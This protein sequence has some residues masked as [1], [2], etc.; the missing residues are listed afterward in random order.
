MASFEHDK[1][2]ISHTFKGNRKRVELKSGP[3]RG[4]G[5]K[6][7]EWVTW[8]HDL[9]HDDFKRFKAIELKFSPRVLFLV[10]RNAL[11]TNPHP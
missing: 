6:I 3:R 11:L 8:L 2:S 4:R 1:L 5:R 10:A 7:V 9:I